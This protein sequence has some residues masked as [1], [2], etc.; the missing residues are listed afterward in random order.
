MI[1]NVGKVEAKDLVD[2]R[3]RIRT[4]VWKSL[5]PEKIEIIVHS[6]FLVELDI[7]R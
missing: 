5:K 7:R 6:F 3:L 1:G 4:K 2:K